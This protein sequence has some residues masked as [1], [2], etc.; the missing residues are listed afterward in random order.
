MERQDPGEQEFWSKRTVYT[1]KRTVTI[2][3]TDKGRILHVQRH[4]RAGRAS[5]GCVGLPRPATRKLEEKRA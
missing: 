4:G 2:C 3:K 1:A 5:V